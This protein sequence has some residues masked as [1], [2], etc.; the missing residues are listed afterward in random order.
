MVKKINQEVFHGAVVVPE[1][2]RFTRTTTYGNTNSIGVALNQSVILSTF[3]GKL[4]GIDNAQEVFAGKE[5]L[6]QVVEA[7]EGLGLPADHKLSLFAKEWRDRNSKAP[8]NW[9]L[10]GWYVW[11]NYLRPA[12]PAF[13]YF[14]DYKLL[15]GKVNLETLRAHVENDTLTDS[16]ET[17]LG[18]FDLAGTNLDELISEEGYENSRAKLEAI[19]LM[20]TQ[21][22]FDYWKQNQELTVEFDIKTDPKDDAPFNSGKNLYIRIKN[23]RHG[24]SVPFDQ[25]SK[26]FIWFFSFLVWFSAVKN[27]VGTEKELILLLDEPGLNLHA[28]AQ[29]DFLGYIDELAKSYQIIYSTHSPFM[30]ASDRLDK[31]RVV[32]DKGKEGTRVS[33][34][35]EA[36]SDESVFPLQAALGY[37]I[38]QNLFIAKKNVLIE[39]P[40]DLIILQHMSALLEGLGRTSLAEGVLVPTGGLDK[41]VTF[42]ALLGASK[43]KLAVLSDKASAPSQKLEELIRQ[44]LIERRRVLDYSMFK[45]PVATEA[46]L[47]DLLPISL[48][49]QAFNEVY[50]SELGSTPI[51]E[52]DLPQHPR[53]VQRINLWLAD[54][55]IRISRDGGFNHYRVAQA[56]APKL[57][58]GIDAQV[59]TGFENLFTKLNNALS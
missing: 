48:Y 49:V 26:G 28:L 29:S 20:I 37:S 6:D 9:D 57:T 7:I 45:S 43:L 38:A 51:V 5:S 18:L 46:D 56:V 3:K 24:V 44:K 30:V 27:R 31:V 15:T 17:M 1:N 10:A 33:S 41:I 21:Q 58:S 8:Q 14:D 16:D 25:R 55:N 40:A 59:L 39:G 13:L 42:V 47:E 52:A 23:N 19:G 35:L 50:A 53:L 11:E 12:L 22:I 32:E 4:A 54:K 34:S 2:F 36:S